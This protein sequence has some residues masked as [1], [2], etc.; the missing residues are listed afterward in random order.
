MAVPSSGAISLWGI[1]KEMEV[2]DYDSSI[3]ISTY[4]SYHATPSLT[5]M[6]TGGTGFDDISTTNTPNGS[7]SNRP[8][9]STPHAMSEFYSYDHDGTLPVGDY[10]N[11][12]S[13]ILW[14]GDQS[15]TEQVD[16]VDISRREYCG[17]SVI[18][19]T[20]H[21][22][23][24][25]ESTGAYR[26]DAQLYQIDYIS[27]NGSSYMTPGVSSIIYSQFDT[28]RLTTNAAYDHSATW[29]QVAAGT[30]A[31]RWNRDTGGTPSSGTGVSLSSHLYYEGSSGGYNMDVYL[32]SPEITFGTNTIYLKTY[33]YGAD[34]GTLYMGVYITG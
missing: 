5:L 13:N 15:T 29:H 2:D 18:G 11:G 24:R 1:A 14:T 16:A 20:G 32:R 28:T 9:G 31:G 6:S 23:W 33:G 27:G 22:Y 3:P 34:M 12:A 17:E 10:G 7:P 8:D 4:N 26:Q 19:R 25:I 30:T 21:V